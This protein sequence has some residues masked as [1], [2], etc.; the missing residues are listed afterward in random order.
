MNINKD[1]EICKRKIEEILL[2]EYYKLKVNFERELNS[3]IE[4]IKDRRRSIF[5]IVCLLNRLNFHGYSTRAIYKSYKSL[6]L[7]NDVHYIFSDVEFSRF[8][9]KWFGYR[10]I[11]K[12]HKGKKYRIF[13]AV[14][15]VT[16]VTTGKFKIGSRCGSR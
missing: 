11:N 6:C 5:I 2:D 4:K 16:H 8:I 1:T 3:S 14:Q 13:I 12:K 10:I 15:D 9:C 7:Q